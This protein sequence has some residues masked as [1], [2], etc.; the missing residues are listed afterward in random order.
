MI[1]KYIDMIGWVVL[2]ITGAV[3]RC[4]P[5][6][7]DAEHSASAPAMHGQSF[8]VVGWLC[9]R[10]NHTG[11]GSH[12]TQRSVCGENGSSRG[13][14]VYDRLGSWSLII[15]NWLIGTAW[16]RPTELLAVCEFA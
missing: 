8:V 5:A 1:R 6:I 11:I 12:V 9:G 3:L 14:A 16:Q 15:V 10:G 4:L 2:I 13:Y 7:G